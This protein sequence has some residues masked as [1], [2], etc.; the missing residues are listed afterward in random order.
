MNPESNF[1]CSQCSHLAVLFCTCTSEKP[2][3]CSDHVQSHSQKPGAHVFGPIA[4]REAINTV[5][6][7]D[8]YS[9]KTRVISQLKIGVQRL[10]TTLEREKHQFDSRFDQ[11]FI[12]WVEFLRGEFGEMR[13]EVEKMYAALEAD[14]TKVSLELFESVETEK[15]EFSE[16]TVRFLYFAQ[17]FPEEEVTFVDASGEFEQRIQINCV[18]KSANLR[19]K[20]KTVLNQGKCFGSKCEKC[21]ETVKV[22][23]KGKKNCVF[24]VCGGCGEELMLKEYGKRCKCG[25]V[26]TQ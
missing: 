7:F 22:M 8:A 12:D 14:I 10:K 6:D 5:S 3:L 20:L 1:S 2:L 26:I 17:H 13:K 9:T 18:R 21:A 15:E 19:G 16:E 25:V 4:A 23:L 11:L 24:L